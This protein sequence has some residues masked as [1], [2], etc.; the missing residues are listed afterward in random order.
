MKWVIIFSA[1]I[2]F[3]PSCDNTG[4]NSNNVKGDSGKPQ[5]NAHLPAPATIDTSKLKVD[6]PLRK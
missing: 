2:S 5:T 1:L 3:L 4:S 6:S